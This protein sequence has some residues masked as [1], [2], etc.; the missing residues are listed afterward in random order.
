VSR[1]KIDTGRMEYRPAGRGLGLVAALMGLGLLAL[2]V[3]AAG[4]PWR[5][6]NV[7]TWVVGSFGALLGAGGLYLL[8][9]GP[10]IWV[11]D[12]ER[13]EILPPPRQR[14]SPLPLTEVEAV[15]LTS[16]HRFGPSIL[17]LCCRD[18]THTLEVIGA[19]ERPTVRVLALQLAGFLG[20]P[21]DDQTRAGGPGG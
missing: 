11:F 2:C 13:G 8:W 16:P 9:R 19:T 5:D 14:G 21:F 3:L 6:W 4:P 1:L 12:L 18:G 10:L 17:L 7:G 15:V 20:V